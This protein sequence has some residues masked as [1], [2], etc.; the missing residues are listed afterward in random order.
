MEARRR[1]VVMLGCGERGDTAG[2]RA[3][4]SSIGSGPAGVQ[5]WRVACGA[6]LRSSA[7]GMIVPRV[8]SMRHMTLRMGGCTR[9]GTGG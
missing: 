4:G 1:V 7:G 2:G 9:A 5:P 8:R 6:W 3:P